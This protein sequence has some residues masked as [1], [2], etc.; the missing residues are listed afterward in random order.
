M[1]SFLLYNYK[2]DEILQNSNEIREFA[3]MI[4]EEL[5]ET[6]SFD[7]VSIGEG[8]CGTI[9]KISDGKCLKISPCRE[10]QDFP[11]NLKNCQNLCTPLQTYRS[12]SGKYIGSVQN[13]LNLY[14][15]QKYIE[16]KVRLTEE[17]TAGLIYDILNALKQL[18]ENGYVHRDFYPG[19]IMLDSK[20]GKITAVVIDFDEMQKSDLK[21]KACFRY[22][23]YH[24]PEIVLDDN[25]YDERSEMF[26]LGVIMWEL[27]FGTCAFGGY[28]FFGRIINTSWMRYE[29][30][31]EAC[32]LEIRERLKMLPDC[33]RQIKGISTEC[34]E[35]LCSLLAFRKD[36][37][38]TASEAMKHD[39]FKKTLKNNNNGLWEGFVE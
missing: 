38:P 31:K 15:L 9:W 29:Q 24:A 20:D 30:N 13:Y 11:E 2:K 21:M 34:E 18:H 3:Q 10:V 5:G 16:K 17:Q 1:R 33:M 4:C 6:L 39:F 23:G 22:N 14:S 32:H 19:N 27:L 8:Y 26:S 37:R 25:A 12:P 7:G 28:D 35:L 36:D